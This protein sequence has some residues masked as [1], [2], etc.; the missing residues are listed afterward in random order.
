MGKNIEQF[1]DL[2]I[3]MIDN[4]LERNFRT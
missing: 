4:K 3:L 1:N 2:V